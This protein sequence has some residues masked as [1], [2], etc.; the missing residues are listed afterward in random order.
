MSRTIKAI[1]RHMVPGPKHRIVQ[2][3]GRNL[4][5]E[6][7]Q[8]GPEILSGHAFRKLRLVFAPPYSVTTAGA[9]D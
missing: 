8:R 5:G 4:V 6:W 1:E 3:F 9:V 2:P 7:Q